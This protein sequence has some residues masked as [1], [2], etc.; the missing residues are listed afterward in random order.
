MSPG[1]VAVASIQ[2]FK[3]VLLVWLVRAK[4][5]FDTADIVFDSVG[6]ADVLVCSRSQSSPQVCIRPDIIQM[7]SKL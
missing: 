7:L 5:G 3:H 4:N 1:D 6:M 2:E